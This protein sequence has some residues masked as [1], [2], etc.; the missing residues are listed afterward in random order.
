MR[1]VC[2]VLMSMGSSACRLVITALKEIHIRVQLYKVPAERACMR[3]QDPPVAE[4]EKSIPILF[5]GWVVP[6]TRRAAMLHELQVTHGVAVTLSNMQAYKCAQQT[7]ACTLN[8]RSLRLFRHHTCT[9]SSGFPVL[10]V[11]GA[12]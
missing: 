3:A 5:Y 4:A 6:G 10:L 7:L 9:A 1:G 12:L 2:L 11:L 8:P